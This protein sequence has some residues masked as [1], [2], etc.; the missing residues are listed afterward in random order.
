MRIRHAEFQYPHAESAMRDAQWGMRDAECEMRNPQCEMR[1]RMRNPKKYEQTVRNENRAFL[2]QPILM[3][4][5][6]NSS[7]VKGFVKPQKRYQPYYFPS[8]RFPRGHCTVSLSIFFLIIHSRI[9]SPA[10]DPIIH[11]T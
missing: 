6:E 9:R 3:H 5:H 11:P 4:D 1:I 8:A 10:I 7:S 2:D